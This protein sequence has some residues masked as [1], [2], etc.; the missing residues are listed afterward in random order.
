MTEL[1]FIAIGSNIEPEVNLPL[2]VRRLTSLGIVRR[3]SSVYRNPALGPRGQPD[4]ANAAALL[5]T[6]LPPED[7]RRELRSIEAELGRVRTPDKFAPR[8][9]DLDLSLYGDQVLEIE[10]SRLPDPEL[11]E[12]A[13]LALTLAEL[14]PKFPHPEDD[15]TLH[16]IADSLRP[17]AEL[18]IDPVLTG[19]VAQEIEGYPAE[20]RAGESEQGS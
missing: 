1:A 3:V 2:A 5:E 14:S 12:R 20:S 16:E 4:F 8:T 18:T 19:L 11:Q 17:G 6:E 13:Y 9:I 7:L 15:R 10:G